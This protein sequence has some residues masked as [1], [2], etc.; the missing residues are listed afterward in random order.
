MWIESIKV[1]EHFFSGPFRFENTTQK[2]NCDKEEYLT[3]DPEIYPSQ[4]SHL[5]NSYNLLKNMLKF[6]FIPLHHH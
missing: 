3:K 5:K 1:K 6:I 2:N 4:K